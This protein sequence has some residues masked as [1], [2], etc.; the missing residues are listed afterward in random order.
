LKRSQRHNLDELLDPLFAEDLR[1]Y[2]GLIRLLERPGTVLPL[3]PP[4]DLSGNSLE[5]RRAKTKFSLGTCKKHLLG[6]PDR[7]EHS[8]ARIFWR[9]ATGDGERGIEAAPKPIG[10]VVKYRSENLYL[11]NGLPNAS[12]LVD[13]A[14]RRIPVRAGKH[15]VGALATRAQECNDRRQQVVSLPSRMVA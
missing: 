8:A 9:V 12:K 7:P 11:V 15:M 6:T 14:D 2:G 3:T 13:V 1:W 5:E 10:L 4:P